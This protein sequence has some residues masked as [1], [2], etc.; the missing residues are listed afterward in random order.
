MPEKCLCCCDRGLDTGS[1][2]EFRKYDR[3]AVGSYFCENYFLYYADKWLK[4]GCAGSA[5]KV[6]LVIPCFSQSVLGAG[7]EHISKIL[8]KYRS[9]IDEV[10][11]NDLGMLRWVTQMRFSVRIFL[12]RVFWK[13]SR[14][15]R[16]EK[17]GSAGTEEYNDRL[18][19]LLGEYPVYGI[20]IEE[21]SH[22]Y[23][24]INVPKGMVIAY[25]FPWC[26]MSY[27][28]ICLYASVPQ[29]LEKKYRAGLPCAFECLST[30]IVYPVN[31]R[32]C[33]RIGKAVYGRSRKPELGDN[34]VR[35]IVC[36]ILK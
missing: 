2:T 3:I 12:G 6:T 20:E 7:K 23:R 18:L 9:V 24:K 14:D 32:S 34:P 1:E 10:C 29:P 15:I 27:G 4:K 19:A 16:M 11:V 17:G 33:L 5:K 35:E 26:Y 31:G 8:Q 22:L 21:L 30:Q 36:D 25:H 28:R 13:A